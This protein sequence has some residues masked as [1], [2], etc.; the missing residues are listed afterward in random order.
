MILVPGNFIRYSYYNDQTIIDKLLSVFSYLF[1][2]VT[3]RA[4]GEFWN[5]FIPWIIILLSFLFMSCVRKHNNELNLSF[6]KDDK[7]LFCYFLTTAIFALIPI[8]ILASFATART[9]F[10]S[11][12]FLIIAI[13]SLSYSKYSD[14]QYDRQFKTVILIIVFLAINAFFLDSL[15]T[16]ARM[17]KLKSEIVTREH[18]IQKLRNNCQRD[19]PLEP[20]L[21]KPGRTIFF[22][23]ISQNANNEFNMHMARYYGIN[24]IRVVTS[25]EDRMR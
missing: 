8:L 20:I 17:W 14:L 25:H 16:T 19:I 9:A 23:D 15:I 6:N 24:S 5:A 7:K 21:T 1:A 13:T 12:Y 10:F 4:S 22:E 18:Y 11:I 3:S 2:V